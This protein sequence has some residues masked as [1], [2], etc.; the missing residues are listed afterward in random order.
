MPKKIY[1]ED[2][3]FFRMALSRFYVGVC[4]ELKVSLLFPRQP[5][6]LPMR[7]MLESSKDN[8]ID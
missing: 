6:E 2:G 4:S 8:A 5:R 7:S 3:E 1:T